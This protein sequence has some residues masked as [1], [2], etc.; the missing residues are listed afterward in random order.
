MRICC[1]FFIIIFLP[2]HNKNYFFSHQL[3]LSST[4]NCK[5][6]TSIWSFVCLFVR[7]E[8]MKEVIFF[9][10][11]QRI[12]Y[13]FLWRKYLGIDRK[14]VC[15]RT[16]YVCE[17]NWINF[18]WVKNSSAYLRRFYSAEFFHLFKQRFNNVIVSRLK[19]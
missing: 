3:S 13:S 16:F 11:I 4:N 7:F 17:I 1:T 12:N 5:V 8:Q 2:L 15:L 18:V 9:R 19:I 14:S 6:H 10:K